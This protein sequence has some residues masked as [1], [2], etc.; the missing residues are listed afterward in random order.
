MTQDG[1]K[2][3]FYDDLIENKM[4][5]INFIY[6]DCPDICSLST[7]RMAEVQRRTAAAELHAKM[8]T[9]HKHKHGAG[10]KHRH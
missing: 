4:V 6:T 7:A 8:A 3:N 10:H 1:R 9:G 5:V 2:L